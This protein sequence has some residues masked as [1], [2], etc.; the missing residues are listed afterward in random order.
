MRRLLALPDERLRQVGLMA[1]AVGLT[2]VWVAQRL[3]A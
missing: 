3:L 1:A 2:F